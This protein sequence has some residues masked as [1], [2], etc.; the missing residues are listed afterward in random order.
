M[1]SCVAL[2]VQSYL[3]TEEENE[4]INS[5]NKTFQLLVKILDRSVNRKSFNGLSFAT[6]EVLEV[7]TKAILLT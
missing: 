5:S 1:I 4:K 6:T 7:V 2:I 3:V